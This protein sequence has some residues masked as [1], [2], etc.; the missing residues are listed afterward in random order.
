[1]VAVRQRVQGTLR[2]H[3]R[4]G[5]TGGHLPP[6]GEVSQPPLPTWL[7]DRMGSSDVSK[8]PNDE[9]VQPTTDQ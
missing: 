7:V 2:D 9:L 1:M 4:Q 5:R 6:S 8:L 3:I